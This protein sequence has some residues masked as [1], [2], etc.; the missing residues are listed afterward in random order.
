VWIELY[1]RDVCIR[2]IIVVQSCVVAG[3]ATRMSISVV[4]SPRTRYHGGEA[5]AASVD[6]G[7]HYAFNKLKT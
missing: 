6:D 5:D 3:K 7:F 4:E 2:A 1:D